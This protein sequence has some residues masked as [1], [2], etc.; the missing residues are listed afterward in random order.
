MIFIQFSQ[1]VFELNVRIFIV[2]QFGYTLP[3][4][5]GNLQQ[6]QV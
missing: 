4:H 2:V 6:Y 1:F 3:I 5:F